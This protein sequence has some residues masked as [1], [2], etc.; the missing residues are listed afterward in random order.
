MEW[1]LVVA[2]VGIGLI[3]TLAVYV[4]SLWLFCRG[5]EDSRAL[6]RAA[7]WGV[8]AGGLVG[9]LIAGGVLALAMAG[10]AEGADAVVMLFPLLGIPV[11]AIP[12]AYAAVALVV[13][14]TGDPERQS[15]ARRGA[16]Y[17]ACILGVLAVISLVISIVRGSV[18]ASAVQYWLLGLAGWVF[19]LSV[20]ALLG[21]YFRFGGGKV[22]KR[23]GAH[24]LRRPPLRPRS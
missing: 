10:G 16:L 24:H 18:A 11:G 21:G 20:G 17:A 5:Q 14:S 4:V 2:I 8:L 1:L 19:W 12:G 6:A 9:L 7:W 22:A 15:G 23:P 13:G 3:P